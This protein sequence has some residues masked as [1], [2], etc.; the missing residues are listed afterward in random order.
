MGVSAYSDVETIVTDMLMDIISGHVTDNMK[1]AN[2]LWPDDD[3]R[4]RHEASDR[5]IQ[6]SKTS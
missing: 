6:V 5:G 2:V 4:R 1:L 3:Q